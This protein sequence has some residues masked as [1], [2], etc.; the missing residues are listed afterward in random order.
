M[1]TVLLKA[2]MQ[3][4]LSLSEHEALELQ[5]SNTF[6]KKTLIVHIS[7]PKYL[8]LDGS[9]TR[10]YFP[11]SPKSLKRSSKSGPNMQQAQP[12][13]PWQGC[14]KL[15]DGWGEGGWGDE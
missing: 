11:Q 9:P 5:I 2:E 3:R 1:N 7:Q 4:I 12:H 14:S 6:I 13:N 15:F 8:H 10:F